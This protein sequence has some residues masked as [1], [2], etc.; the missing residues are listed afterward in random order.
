M[1]K[2]IASYEPVEIR[3]AKELVSSLL[4]GGV[5]DRQ[6]LTANIQ[7]LAEDRLFA[8][9]EHLY[10]LAVLLI[11]LK[12]G[13]VRVS[14]SGANNNVV[15]GKGN[16]IG[17]MNTGA[18]AIQGDHNVLTD[19]SINIGQ[20]FNEKHERISALA[21]LLGRLKAAEEKN[22]DGWRQ[23]RTLLALLLWAMKSLKLARRFGS[24]SVFRP[25]AK[26][27]AR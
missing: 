6:P 8:D 3:T 18:G 22:D 26:S 4:L 19:S 17:S 13:G 10:D 21:D 24:C 1:P 9:N 14:V 16:T 2:P 20:S 15:V 25:V 11:S 5:L 23:Q 12:S 27:P 7:E